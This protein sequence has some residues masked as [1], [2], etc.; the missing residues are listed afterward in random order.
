MELKVRNLS[1]A[2]SDLDFT[3][4]IHVTCCNHQQNK[5]QFKL[6]VLSCP[7]ANAALPWL[8][9]ESIVQHRIA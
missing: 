6:S 1:S 7:A 4:E 8:S 9:R 3:T 5:S 2:P